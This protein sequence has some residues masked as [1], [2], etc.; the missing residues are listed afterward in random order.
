MQCFAMPESRSERASGGYPSSSP[1]LRAG[2]SFP[3]GCSQNADHPLCIFLKK[4]LQ[5]LEPLGPKKAF[6]NNNLGAIRWTIMGLQV[7][8]C[9]TSGVWIW[10]QGGLPWELRSLDM[11]V[12]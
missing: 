5:P 3:L 4:H 8:A 6:Y 9:G 1:Q 11:G 12:G 10:D 7:A 2:C